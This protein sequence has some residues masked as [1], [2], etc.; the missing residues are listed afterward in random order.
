VTS[1]F[2]HTPVL[3]AETVEALQPRPGRRYIDATL[4]AGGHAEK[5][6]ELSAPDGVVL[7]IDADPIALEAASTRLAPFGDRLIT[8]NA[9]FDDLVPVARRLGIDGVD[10]ILFDLGVSSP[11]LAHAERGF[12]FQLEGP[13]DMRMGPGATASAAELVNDAPVSELQRIFQEYGEERYA[14]RIAQRIGEARAHRPIETTQELA[15]IVSRAVP[16]G[17]RQR[18]HPATRVFQ[19]LRIAVND[20]L[21]RLRRALPQA[22]ELLNEGGRLVV[23]S[24]HS[25]EDRIVKQFMRDE[26]RGCVCPPGLPACGCGRTA[27]LRQLT[28][29]PISASPR[30][31]EENPR[32]RSAR[33]RAAV[34]YSP[35]TDPVKERQMPA[36]PIE[37]QS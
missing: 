1:G 16:G 8:A 9:Y 12:S 13:L 23:I 27:T 37:R 26:A 11:Q 33:L 25:L 6:L 34:R 2:A 24:F 21:G 30:E 7:G 18:I 36:D 28:S 35:P 19:A 15:A 14:R 32:A 17:R 3:L 22:V 5:V 20:E 4:G 29:R 31:A 10:G